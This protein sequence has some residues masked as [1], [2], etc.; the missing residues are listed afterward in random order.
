MT[1]NRYA[2]RRDSNEG[3][4]I[5]AARECGLKV[6]VTSELGD[7]LAQYGKVT[8]VIEVKTEDGR[9]TKAQEFR[10]A[11]GLNTHIVRTVDDVLELR[12]QMAADLIKLT[13]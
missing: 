7:W 3:D 11:Q 5:T 6:W 10:R 1:L 8:R 9:L 4:L 13:R 2:R 12:R